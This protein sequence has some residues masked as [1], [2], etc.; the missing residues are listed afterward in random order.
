MPHQFI[1][2][3]E[4]FVAFRTL[5]RLLARVRA[6]VAVQLP[7]PDERLAAHAATVRTHARMTSLMVFQVFRR[8]ERF[9][10]AVTIESFARVRFL[11]G[12]R[13]C[14]VAVFDVMI[15]RV[16]IDDHLVLLVLLWWRF[17]RWR[18]TVRVIVVRRY[19]E[20]LAQNLQFF[21]FVR[22]FL[23][24]VLFL[25]PQQFVPPTKA[26]ITVITPELFLY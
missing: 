20:I 6:H 25:V 13:R 12:F 19:A 7:F 11:T 9:I 10:A 4:A 8:R 16:Q 26:Q 15:K 1:L 3:P 2:P 14:S 18:R 23:R 21:S 22:M 24:I 5:E 17:A